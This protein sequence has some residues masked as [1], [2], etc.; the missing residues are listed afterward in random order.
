[1]TIKEKLT[2]REMELR[3]CWKD[4][5][6]V[7]GAYRGQKS[8]RI[9]RNTICNVSIGN[10]S[11][12]LVIRGWRIDDPAI[13]LDSS[14]LEDLGVELGGT[15]DVTLTPVFWAGYWRWAWGAADPAY[16]IAAQI[17]IISLALGVIGLAL[18]IIALI[19]K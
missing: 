3:D 12:L 14:T 13:A 8:H 9:H 11:K 1:M 7:P 6:R 19:L 16:R 5:A 10:K 2:V 17:S 18:G 15:Y 4:M